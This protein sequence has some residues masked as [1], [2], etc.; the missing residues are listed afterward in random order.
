L[1]KRGTKMEEGGA[2]MEKRDMNRGGEK[3]SYE[4]LVGALSSFHREPPNPGIL[5][6]KIMN[7][8]DYKDSRR[9]SRLTLGGLIFGWTSVAWVRRSM[10]AASIAIVSLFVYQQ[11]QI[12]TGLRA[13]ESKLSD[14]LPTTEIRMTTSGNEYLNKVMLRERFAL[15]DSIRVSVADIEALIESYN[16]LQIS[17]EKISRFLKMNPEFRKRIESEYG[18]SFSSVMSK[19]KI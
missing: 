3:E 13:L 14:G 5:A 9:V 8:I 6:A 11:F 10:M 12:M 16:E 19:P 4:R 7:R 15:N 18:E 17:Y 2:R 1:E